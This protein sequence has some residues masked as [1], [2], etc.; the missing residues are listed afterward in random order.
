MKFEFDTAHSRVGMESAKWDAIG[1][2][3]AQDL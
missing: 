1:P 2:N 3:P